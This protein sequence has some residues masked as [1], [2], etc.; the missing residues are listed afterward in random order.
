M[1]TRKQQVCLALLAGW[2]S[3]GVLQAQESPALPATAKLDV[4]SEEIYYGGIFFNR[5]KVQNNREKTIWFPIHKRDF[6][7]GTNAILKQNDAQVYQWFAMSAL[8]H[9]EYLATFFYIRGPGKGLEPCHEIAVHTIEHVFL[10]PLWFPMPEYSDSP[11]ALEIDKAVS[12]GKQKYLVR[13]STCYEEDSEINFTCPIMVKPRPK[14]DF[15]L[16]REWFLELPTTKRVVPTTRSN[17]S[18]LPRRSTFTGQAS[19]ACPSNSKKRAET[20]AISSGVLC[21]SIMFA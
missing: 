13:F 14:D 1:K 2:I 17:A 16:L 19:P 11:E 6:Y 8:D 7:N 21:C 12:F 5:V 15:E 3:V 9:K 4:Y 18:G 20:S 10:R